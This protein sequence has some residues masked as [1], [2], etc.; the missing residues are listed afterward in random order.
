MTTFS[1][2]RILHAHCATFSD[3]PS[4]RLLSSIICVIYVLMVENHVSHAVYARAGELSGTIEPIP[5]FSSRLS[6]RSNGEMTLMSN[7]ILAF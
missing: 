3:R 4:S 5:S 7:D 6:R 2:H 1:Y